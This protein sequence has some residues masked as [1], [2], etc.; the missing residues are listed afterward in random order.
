MVILVAQ[1]VKSLPAMQ[2]TRVQ[3]WVGKITS[4]RKWLPTPAFLPGEFHGER[5][6]GL[7]YMWSQS[8][9]GQSDLHFHFSLFIP[10]VCM[11]DSPE[12]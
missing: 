9:T 3:L 6:L 11:G 5:S 10:P 12:N 2:E 1:M 7:Q 8:Q 4:R